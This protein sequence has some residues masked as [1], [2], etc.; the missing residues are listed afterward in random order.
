M[1]S[2]REFCEGLL[3]KADIQ[4]D[5]SRPQ[6]IT[7]RDERLFNRVIRYGTLG[8]G[9]A[10]MDGW[11]DAN[12]LDEF[13]NKVLRAH[14]DKEI[15]INIASVLTVAKAFLF[16]K[17]SSKKAF[18]VG[19]A[20]YDLGNDL[21]EAMLDKRMVYTCG[22]WA[23]ANNLDDAQEAKL[24]LVCKKI[25]LK[26]GG[27]ILDIGCGWGSFAKYAAEKYGA[28]VVGITVSVEQAALA[29]ER[30]AGLPVEIRVCD[31]REVNPSNQ[32][33]AGEQFDHIISLGMFEHVG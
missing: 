26:K 33:G 29:R 20:H 10:Y 32:L 14:L 6:D 31:Y 17:Q 5:G 24:D 3:K 30:C 21:Y 19:E 22:Y 28:T 7:I 2:A 11:W 12:W 8:L 23:H 9:E 4:I 15:Q 1:A 25:G 16:N 18:E 13:F 27:R